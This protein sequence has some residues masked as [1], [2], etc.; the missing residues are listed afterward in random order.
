MLHNKE[1]MTEIYEQLPKL[2]EADVKAP[3]HI[4]CGGGGPFP[5]TCGARCN[6]SPNH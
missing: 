1:R 2:T 4:N 6:I 3:R 5:V